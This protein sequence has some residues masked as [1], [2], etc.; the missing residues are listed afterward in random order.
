MRTVILTIVAAAAITSCKKDD[1]VPAPSAKPERA[2]KAPPASQLLAPGAEL[3]N[4]DTVAHDGTAIKSSELRG[5][6]LV[7]Y[8]YP[9]DE[10]GGCNAEAEAFRDAIPEMQTMGAKIVGVSTD[11]LE[12]HRSFAANHKLNFPL[13]ADSDM[14]VAQAFG[15]STA[16]GH[17]DRVT[18]V[19]KPNG[20]LARVFA[21]VSVDGHAAEVLAALREARGAA[22]APTP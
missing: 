8:F 15:V 6:P 13:V 4:I 21:D 7:V 10:T 14:K 17:A 9:E 11:T 12:A 2:E 5:S 22:A 19:F 16:G 20:V 3:P 1:K 18:F